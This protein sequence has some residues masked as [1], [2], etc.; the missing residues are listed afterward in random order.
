MQAA[1]D[2]VAY[3]LLLLAILLLDFVEVKFLNSP[4]CA[5]PSQPLLARLSVV[6][7]INSARS[8]AAW[9]GSV[10]SFLASVASTGKVQP[11]ALVINH[12][13]NLVEQLF[14]LSLQI[15]ALVGTGLQAVI[16]CLKERQALRL[17][18][19]GKEGVAF[20][21][22]CCAIVVTGVGGSCVAFNHRLAIK[23][24]Q[25]AELG[26]Q[27]GLLPCKVCNRLGWAADV[28]AAT[29]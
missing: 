11:Q 25:R 20:V 14:T 2:L 6:K 13:L 4:N 19:D 21:G 29:G 23:A 26:I 15:K 12:Q 28:P 24:L 3:R 9:L 10:A 18:A 27:G 1:L 16:R 8:V 7:L 5:A 22:A 17:N